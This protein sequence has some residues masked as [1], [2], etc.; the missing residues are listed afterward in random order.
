[1]D[2]IDNPSSRAVTALSGVGAVQP[3]SHAAR[4]AQAGVS[5]PDSG[6]RI[7]L[8]ST[9]LAGASA[10]VDED[11]VAEIRHAV[12]QGRYPVVPTRIADAMIAAGYLLRA[13][14]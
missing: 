12:E 2:R 11:R 13:G 3:A 10:P 5:A 6:E 4:T 8:D 14:L 7:T 9:A 1:M